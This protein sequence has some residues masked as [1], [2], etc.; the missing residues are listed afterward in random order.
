MD[1]D[2]KDRSRTQK[3]HTQDRS[4][5][6]GD[7]D[8]DETARLPFK[9]QQFHSQ[10]QGRHRGAKHCG[11]AC[12]RACHQQCLALCSAEM[13][14]LGKERTEG[15]ARHDDRPF[16]TKG[17]ASADGDGGGQGLKQC[18]L[19]LDAAAAQQDGL[20]RLRDAVTANLFRAISRHESDQ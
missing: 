9:Q 17:T 11:H 12:R 1:I 20:E 6:R 10:Q 18:H 4:H 14:T 16:G 15:S 13:E 5:Y 3:G 2:R 7:G 19:E 8:R